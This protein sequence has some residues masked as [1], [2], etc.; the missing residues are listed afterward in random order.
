LQ[1][2]SNIKETQW[3]QGK[4]SELDLLIFNSVFSKKNNKRNPKI[5]EKITGLRAI[6]DYNKSDIGNTENCDRYKE[7]KTSPVE[8]TE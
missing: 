6:S 2:V 7:V 1:C 4:T 8:E 3:G 5:Q